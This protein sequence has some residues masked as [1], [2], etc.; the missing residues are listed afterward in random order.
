MFEH[1]SPVFLFL[2][3]LDDAP[4]LLASELGGQDLRAVG[5]L[6]LAVGQPAEQRPRLRAP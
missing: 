2:P 6:H 5:L 1:P 4:E 3:E